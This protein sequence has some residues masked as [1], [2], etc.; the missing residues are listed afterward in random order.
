MN[1]KTRLLDAYRAI[2]PDTVSR[3]MSIGDLPAHTREEH[4]AKLSRS[5]DGTFGTPRQVDLEKHG[6]AAYVYAALHTHWREIAAWT[7]KRDWITES[8]KA[9]ALADVPPGELSDLELG[10]RLYMAIV[11]D[12]PLSPELVKAITDRPRL[13]LAD[14][15]QGIGLSVQGYASS[16]LTKWRSEGIPAKKGIAAR[17]LWG[18]WRDVGNFKKE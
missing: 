5:A 7:G 12:D 11:E 2:G 3:L 16:G 14:I 18:W 4:F 13:P 17:A 6:Q 15:A 10:C 8:A 1:T 9:A